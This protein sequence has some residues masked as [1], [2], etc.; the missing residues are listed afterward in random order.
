MRHAL[1]RFAR[2][3]PAFALP[4]RHRTAQPVTLTTPGCI[5]PT[6]YCF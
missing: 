6:L 5:A 3:R 1:P 4:R 2:P